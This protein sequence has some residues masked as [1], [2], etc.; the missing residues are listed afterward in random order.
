VRAIW[1]LPQKTASISGS[2]A[3]RLWAAWRPQISL[4]APNHTRSPATS[5]PWAASAASKLSARTS[6]L[7]L[8]RYYVTGFS[9]GAIKA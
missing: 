4:H 9:A 8:Q 6:A 1:S 2:A 5:T 7:F 3:T